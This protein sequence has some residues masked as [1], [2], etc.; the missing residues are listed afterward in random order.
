MLDGEVG[1]EEIGR[2]LLEALREIVVSYLLLADLSS[3]LLDFLLQQ[4]IVLLEVL[5]LTMVF[6]CEEGVLLL[7]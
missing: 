2:G 6:V 1:L 5:Y 4:K 3:H 7:Q